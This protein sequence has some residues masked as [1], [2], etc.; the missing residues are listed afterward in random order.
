[1]VQKEIFEKSYKVS[2]T[3]IV[4]NWIIVTWNDDITTNNMIGN[5]IKHILIMY[6]NIALK[7]LK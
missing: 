5:T 4:P 7:L 2:C 3:R 1:M 6:G